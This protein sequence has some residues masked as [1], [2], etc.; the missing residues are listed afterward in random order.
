MKSII[1]ASVLLLGSSFSF[2][3]TST[4]EA[5]VYCYVNYTPR[6]YGPGILKELQKVSGTLVE[7]YALSEVIDGKTV[8]V[9]A[10][11][12]PVKSNL[13]SALV[14]LS[15][16]VSQDG[17]PLYQT[18]SVAGIL[19]ASPASATVKTQLAGTQLAA[20]CVLK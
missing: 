15:L 17:A 1:M 18:D 4:D 12:Y 10:E 13:T 20:G 16:K 14:N 6:A 9:K 5:K 3:Q 7:T 2:A 11:L 19:T 8:E